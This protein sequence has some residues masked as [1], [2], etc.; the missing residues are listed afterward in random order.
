MVGRTWATGGALHW[1]RAR[2]G[3]V[4]G[5]SAHAPDGPRLVRGLSPYRAQVPGARGR[6]DARNATHLPTGRADT[7]RGV[8]LPPLAAV[9][10]YLKEPNASAIGGPSHTKPVSLG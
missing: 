5:H 9:P 3:A 10:L 7:A 4:A 1:C 8:L 6:T 2:P